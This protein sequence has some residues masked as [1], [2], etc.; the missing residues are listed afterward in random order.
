M[1]LEL[2]ENTPLQAATTSR[3]AS[4]WIGCLLLAAAIGLYALLRWSISAEQ[5]RSP[6]EKDLG[7]AVLAMLFGI[8]VLLGIAGLG[9]IVAGVCI[10]CYRKYFRRTA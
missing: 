8:P 4:L 10:W 3:N 5:A 2:L 1:G 6:G 7:V 9:F